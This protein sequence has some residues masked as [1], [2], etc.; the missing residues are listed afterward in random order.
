VLAASLWGA[1][2]V[3]AIAAAFWFQD[4]RYALPTPPPAGH[5]D[6][7]IG[8]EVGLAA[9]VARLHVLV[10]EDQDVNLRVVTRMLG[11]LGHTCDVARDGAQALA[12]LAAGTYAV[13]LMDCHMPVLSGDEATV[14]WR[15]RAEGR[16]RTPIVALTANALVS[17]RERSLAAGMDGWLTK[18]LTL[19]ALEAALQRHAAPERS[20]A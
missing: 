11:K 7:P 16:A 4:L 15:E 13:V 20:A 17:D 19:A 8:A 3:A 14:R 10:V 1:G 9:P 2:C 18:P 12:L 6:V 5:R